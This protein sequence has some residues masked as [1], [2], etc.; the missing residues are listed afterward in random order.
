M[1]ENT[2][3]NKMNTSIDPKK[4]CQGKNCDNCMKGGMPFKKETLSFLVIL[5]I[6][7][8]TALSILLINEKRKISQAPET[9]N[10]PMAQVST[11]SI[12]EIPVKPMTQMIDLPQPDLDGNMS[13][14][15]AMYSRRS[16][17]TF[18][19]DQVTMQELSQILWSAQ[20]IT[21]ESGH[22]TAPSGKSA[23]PFTVYIVVRNVEDLDPGL[24]QYLPEE[25][26]LGL[27]GLANAGDLLTSA[28]VQQGAQ[29]API[30]LL[31]TASYG[32]MKAVF[33]DND[34][35]PN[36]LLE[37]GHIGQNVYLQVEAMGMSTVVMGGFNAVKVG[38][39]LNLDPAEDVI[40]LIPVGHRSEEVEESH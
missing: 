39:V 3:P 6:G 22:R 23:Y 31:P 32:K 16:R 38:E 35:V 26:Q 14:E 28:G 30:V 18:S 12:A 7:A 2:V 15:K 1:T 19:Q 17:R 11:V 33:P 29:D 25:H 4:D 5:L 13:L 10:Q 36:T 40:Y 34:P 8:V 37:A 27:L 24:Y 21:D 9:T 20:G